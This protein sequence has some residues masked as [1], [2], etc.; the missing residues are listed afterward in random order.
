LLVVVAIIA[1]LIGIL[2]PALGA[3]REAAKQTICQTHHRQ[4]M[5]TSLMYAN[6]WDGHLPLPNWE[7]PYYLGPGWLFKGRI[8]PG[9]L[10]WEKH[11]TGVLWPYLEVDDIYR[12]PSHKEP[13]PR[14]SQQTTSY[15]M[16]GAVQGFGRARTGFQVHRYRN[17][18]I[19]FWEASELSDGWNDGSSYP[20][21]GMTRRHGKGATVSVIDGHTQWLTHG[22]YAEQLTRRPGMLWC[23]PDSDNGT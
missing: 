6:D 13:F 10:K 4:L 21:E 8:P 22:D 19:I 7:P 9:A 5:T 18:A 11:Q 1:L 17:D 2:L 20:T 12:C 15:L 23:A 16:N 14:N 3:A